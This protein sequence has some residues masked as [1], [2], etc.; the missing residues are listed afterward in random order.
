MKEGYGKLIHQYCQLLLVKL[1]FHQK[2]PGFPGNLLV[3]AE[4]LEKISENDMNNYF[5]MAVEMFDYMDEILSLQESSEQINAIG[6]IR[7][8]VT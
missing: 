4:D 5:Q 2:N 3:S 8:I 6:L 1:D 7:I